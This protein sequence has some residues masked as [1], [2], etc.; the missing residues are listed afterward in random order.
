MLGEKTD[1]DMIL[2]TVTIQS[3]MPYA[4]AFEMHI[5]WELR[6]TD[7]RSKK[8]ALRQTMHVEWINKPW[9]ASVLE[10]IT[11]NQYK[12]NADYY[13]AWMQEKGELYA[14]TLDRPQDESSTET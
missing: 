12:V 6:T 11:N 4:D 9:V 7:P 14:Q 10:G 8:V 2:R 1:T 3:G 13:V 5:K